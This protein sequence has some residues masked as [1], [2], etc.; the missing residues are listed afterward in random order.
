MGQ[1]E[2]LK[3][4]KERNIDSP[5]KALRLGVIAELLGISPTSVV[6]NVRKLIRAYELKYI[7]KNRVRYY[8]LNPDV[9]KPVPNKYKVRDSL[10]DILVDKCVAE[11]YL[12]LRNLNDDAKVYKSAAAILSQSGLF[13]TPDPVSYK[14]YPGR[15]FYLTDAGRQHYER[16][17]KRRQI[18]KEL[19]Q[20]ECLL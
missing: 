18:V 12:M 8:Y 6:H 16:K 2:V 14:R 17:Q 9:D 11:G 13:Y 20:G 15:K 3:L 1:S 5:E 4:L 7:V 19:S 10:L